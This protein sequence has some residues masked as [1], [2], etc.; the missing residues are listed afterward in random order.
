MGVRRFQNDKPE[1]QI[2]THGNIKNYVVG[3]TSLPI[4]I[5]ISDHFFVENVV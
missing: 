2:F 4:K 3:I 5:I 1:T